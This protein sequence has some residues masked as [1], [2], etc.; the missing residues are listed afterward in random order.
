MGQTS[1]GAAER[2]RVSGLVS[3]PA[4]RRLS[5]FS[6]M[7]VDL[8]ASS[9]LHSVT[10]SSAHRDDR[11]Q[12]GQRDRPGQPVGVRQRARVDVDCVAERTAMKFSGTK[13][14]PTTA[15]TAA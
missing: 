12:E 9:Y 10:N 15:K 7:R 6:R 4:R 8:C 2:P 5:D 1:W 14:P 3:S 11:E 13:A